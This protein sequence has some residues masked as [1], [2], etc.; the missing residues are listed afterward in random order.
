MEPDRIWTTGWYL[1][2]SRP[3]QHKTHI[4]EESAIQED[5]RYVPMKVVRK[6][7]V[8]SCGAAVPFGVWFGVWGFL[9]RRANFSV[10]RTTFSLHTTAIRQIVGEP[11][12]Q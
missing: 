7:S 10:P 4:P 2:G 11:Q 12:E 5:T 6:S 3:F 1:S 9:R 8:D